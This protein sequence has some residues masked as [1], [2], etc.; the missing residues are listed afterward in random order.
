MIAISGLWVYPIKS[1][2]GIE[3]QTATLTPDGLAWDRH[4]MLVDREG[5]FLTQRQLPRMALIETMLG[6]KSLRVSAPGMSDL[7]V[8]FGHQGANVTATVWRDRC[9][10]ID[11]GDAAGDWFSAVLGM[12]C[13]LVAF[14]ERARRESDP[15]YA[16]DSGASTQFSDGFALLVI[17]EASL[18]ALNERLIERGAEAVPMAR[19]RPNL[20]LRGIEAFDEDHIRDLRG[21]QGL[22]LRLVKPCARC[23]ITTVDPATGTRDEAGEPLVTLNEFR[24]N[25]DFG[26][27]FGQNAIVLGGVVCRLAVGDPLQADWNF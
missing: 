6:E 14:D 25:R 17:G 8:P 26:T 23:L 10:A 2:K 13:R 27:I 9:A 3:L 21:G 20:A 19:F 22:V 11:A 5:R 24:V 16:G 1:C 7:L 18:G 12:Q 15:D 4:W